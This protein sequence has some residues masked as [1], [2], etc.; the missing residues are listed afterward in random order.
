VLLVSGRISIWWT[1]PDL[2]A[3]GTLAGPDVAVSFGLNG[4]EEKKP[5]KKAARH[6]NPA[7]KIALIILRWAARTSAF[8]S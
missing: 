3:C 1:Y 4:L 6:W 7:G 8:G 2:S 5:Q